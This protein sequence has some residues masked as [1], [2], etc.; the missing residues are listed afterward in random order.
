MKRDIKSTWRGYKRTQRAYPLAGHTCEVVGCDRPAEHR[1]HVD[2]DTLNIDP[3]NVVRLCRAHHRIMHPIILTHAEIAQI[4]RS[5]K[6]G[7]VLAARYGIS[8]RYANHIRAGTRL[9]V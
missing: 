8:S 9:R 6:P 2:N 1:H 5:D 4:R 7:S 3:A